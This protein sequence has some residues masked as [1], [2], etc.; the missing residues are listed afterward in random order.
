MQ[1]SSFLIRPSSFPRA[2][3][4]YDF[5]RQMEGAKEVTCSEFDDAAIAKM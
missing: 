5:A 3:V 4:T 2:T 1:H